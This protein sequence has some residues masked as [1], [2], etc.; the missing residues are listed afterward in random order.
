M[1]SNTVLHIGPMKSGKSKELLDIAI[2]LKKRKR[3]YV[4]FKPALDSRNGDYIYSRHYK[5]DY[6]LPVTKVEYAKQIYNLV[7]K[8]NSGYTDV[9]IDEIMLF[10]SDIIGVID[11]FYYHGIDLYAAGLD[12]DFRKYPFQLKDWGVRNHLDEII[13]INMQHVIEQFEEV[14]YH[15]SLCDVCGEKAKYTQRLIDG[16]PASLDS[17]LI[18]IG[19]EEYQAR[20]G[21]HHVIF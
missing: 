13:S 7:V 16:E 11:S 19:D 9:L 20:C 1:P 10:D 18:L 6:V 8:N 2:Q 3:K 17:P 21:K 15:Y 4:C 14:I 5:N 12:M